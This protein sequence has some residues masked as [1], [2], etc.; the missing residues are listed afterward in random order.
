MNRKVLIIPIVGIVL[1]V[2]LAGCRKSA[3]PQLINTM[4]KVN[5]LNTRLKSGS[6]TVTNNYLQ[7]DRIISNCRSVYSMQDNMIHCV[8]SYD[9]GYGFYWDG[10]TEYDYNRK[11]S[12]AYSYAYTYLN[13]SEKDYNSYIG[14][15]LMRLPA[16]TEVR[17]CRKTKSGYTVTLEQSFPGNCATRYVYETD[18]SYL[19]Q[20]WKMGL[21]GNDGIITWES[22]VKV[23][24][25]SRDKAVRPDNLSGNNVHL[26][27]L[28]I[29]NGEQTG[30]ILKIQIPDNFEFHLIGK[31]NDILSYDLDGNKKYTP[32]QIHQ[33]LALYVIGR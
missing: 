22:S 26:L 27:T 32:V 12:S 10:Q 21:V 17:S 33:D 14:K 9:D 28:G 1:L 30:R 15:D 24:A 31:N 19:I 18:A 7:D 29:Q 13:G 2:G 8:K 25:G 23:A 3:D 20:S 5:D 16:K 4:E 6:I 11:D